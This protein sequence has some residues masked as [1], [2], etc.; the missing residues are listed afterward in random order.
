MAVFKKLF[1]A[2]NIKTAF[3]PLMIFAQLK[4]VAPFY[5]TDDLDSKFS[6]PAL[7]FVVFNYAIYVFGCIFTLIRDETITSRM[8]NSFLFKTSDKCRIIIGLF[9]M[10]FIYFNSLLK[11]QF[12]S[13]ALIKFTEIDKL[14]E[15]IGIKKNY[16]SIK[17]KFMLYLSFYELINVFYMF[18]GIIFVSSLEKK[19]S[20]AMNMAMYAPGF[21]ITAILVVFGSYIATLITSLKLLNNQIIKIIENYFFICKRKTRKPMKNSISVFDVGVLHSV[22]TKLFIFIEIYD[23][24]CQ[25]ADIINDYFT[26]SVLVVIGISFVCIVLNMFYVLST[27]VLLLKNHVNIETYSFLFFSLQQCWTHVTN[28]LYAVKICNDMKLQVIDNLS[29]NINF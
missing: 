5:V 14:F 21:I 7:L 4:G 9:T 22:K 8:Y 18:M 3:R 23:V 12:Y 19:P 17:R 26:F 2:T 6:V 29:L 11:R 27:I 25:C 28:T 13:K 16:S 15:S 20:L 10:T 1:S 24:L